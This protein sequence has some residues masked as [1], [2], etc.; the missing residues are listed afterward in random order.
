MIQLTDVCDRCGH[1]RSQHWCSFGACSY[2]YAGQCPCDEFADEDPQQVIMDL[3][4][5][6]AQSGMQLESS[7]RVVQQQRQEIKELKAAL[8]TAVGEA[9]ET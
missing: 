2:N 9:V 1:M 4:D 7:I 5:Q 8:A 3:H 6:L